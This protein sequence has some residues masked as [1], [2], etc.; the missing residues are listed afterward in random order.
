LIGA[1]VKNYI[2]KQWMAKERQARKRWDLK[3][4]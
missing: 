4:L 1:P 2:A 3:I